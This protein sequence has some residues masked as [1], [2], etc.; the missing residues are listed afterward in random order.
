MATK[1]YAYIPCLA[2]HLA[3]SYSRPA[4]L[5]DHSRYSA[6]R[7]SNTGTDSDRRRLLHNIHD[8]RHFLSSSASAQRSDF[9]DNACSFMAHL[10]SIVM[11]FATYRHV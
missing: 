1:M 10:P 9:L 7:V 6:T 8:D 3:D 4:T 11:E 2:L 5:P